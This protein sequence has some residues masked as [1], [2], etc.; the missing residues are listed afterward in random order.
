MWIALLARLGF[1]LLVLTGI[2]EFEIWDSVRQFI[3]YDPWIYLNTPFHELRTNAWWIRTGLVIPSLL[4]SEWT[5]LSRN[6]SFGLYAMIT[7]MLTIRIVNKTVQLLLGP[8]QIRTLC[9]TLFILFVALFMNG[10][11]CFAILGAALLY[12]AHYRWFRGDIGTL[13]LAL[14]NLGA[15]ILMTVSTGAFYVGASIVMTATCLA[16]RDPRP[17]PAQGHATIN[18]MLSAIPATYLVFHQ[19]T[20]FNEKL[21][22]WHDGDYL[23]IVYHGP[24]MLLEKYIPAIPPELLLC[25][26]LAGGLCAGVFWL[27]YA[28]MFPISDTYLITTVILGIVCGAFGWS[29]LLT[30]LPGYILIGWTVITRGQ[31]VIST[32]SAMDLAIN[33]S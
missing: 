19:A 30:N 11:I 18:S 17:G 32:G 29:T 13:R 24:L 16:I 26:L 33:R 9:T 31:P 23:M 25:G 8:S 1:A 10:R 21:F 6:L 7:V 12:S 14:I 20:L 22:R 4:V 28:N 5:P 15:L 2:K 3:S 27:G